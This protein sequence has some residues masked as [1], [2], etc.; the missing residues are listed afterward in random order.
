MIKKKS[1]QQRSWEYSNTDQGLQEKEK[2]SWN[3]NIL[4]DK[5]KFVLE[6]DEKNKGETT[7]EIP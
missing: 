5:S 4:T 3:Q 7:Q 1:L 6:L 2:I